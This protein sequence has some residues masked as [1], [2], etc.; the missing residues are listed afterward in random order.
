MGDC[1]Y[2]E[3]G[4]KRR[5][6]MV[7]ICR[8]KYST[9]YLNRNQK[10]PGRCVVKFQ[11]HKTEY[12]QL[13]KEERDGFF[14]EVAAVAKAIWELYHPDKIN[15]AT[16]G[17]LVPHVHV[18]VVPKYQDGPDWGNPFDD[19]QGKVVLEEKEYQ[20]KAEALKNEILKSF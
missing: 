11:D 9:V 7:E 18:H 1:F 4:E 19:T 3:D 15:Y 13:T 14:E 10:F 12:F 17:D 5:S 16:F 6:L 8:L 20:E 2:C